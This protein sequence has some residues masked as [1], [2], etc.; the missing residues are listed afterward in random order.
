MDERITANEWNKRRE[1]PICCDIADHKV[2]LEG[3]MVV[4]DK[5]GEPGLP[6]LYS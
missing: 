4:D 5:T 1:C 2:D 3:E 6:A